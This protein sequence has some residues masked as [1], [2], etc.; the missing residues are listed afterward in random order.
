MSQDARALL[1]GL[2]GRSIRTP[3][4]AES[5]EILEVRGDNVIVGTKISPGGSPVPIRFVQEALDRLAADGEV[6]IHPGS[7]GHRRSSFVGAVLLTL[8]DARVTSTSPPRVV[9]DASAASS[10]RDEVVGEVNAWWA[11]NPSELY[12]LEITDRPDIGVDLHAPQHDATGGRTPGYSLIWWVSPGDVVFHYDRNERAIVAWSRSIG[13]VAEAPVIWLS[14][15]AATRRS[16]SSP[17]WL[18]ARSRWSLSAV[19]V[20]DAGATAR[21]R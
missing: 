19:S 7:L 2:V 6:E 8:P 20:G 4:R 3:R 14:H 18:V 15:R 12:W 17:T 21:A 11:A 16:C 13:Q 1:L 9:L 5:N 10:Y